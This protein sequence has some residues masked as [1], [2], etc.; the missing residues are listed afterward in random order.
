M[1][2]QYDS[3]KSHSV[4]TTTLWYDVVVLVIFILCERIRI[5]RFECGLVFCV[6]EMVERQSVEVPASS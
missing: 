1:V 5:L 3:N 4:H 6:G 2:G